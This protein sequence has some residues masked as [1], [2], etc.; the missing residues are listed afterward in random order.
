MYVKQQGGSGPLCPQDPDHPLHRQLVRVGDA[1]YEALAPFRDADGEYA[2]DRLYE[3]SQLA[4]GERGMRLFV[5]RGTAMDSQL[6]SIESW[7]WQCPICRFV[8][9]ATSVRGFVEASR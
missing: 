6:T 5:T 9:P 1:V 8:L 3:V 2:D 4:Y 7:F